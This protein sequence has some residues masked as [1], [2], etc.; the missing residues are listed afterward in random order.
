MELTYE[1]VNL[2]RMTFKNQFDDEPIEQIPDLDKE[3]YLFKDC[4]VVGFTYLFKL[5][6]LLDKHPELIYQLHTHMGDINNKINSVTPLH[7]IC[8]HSESD[9][10]PNIIQLLIDSG[11][12]INAKDKYNNTAFNNV[13]RNYNSDKLYEVLKLLIVNNAVVNTQNKD[14]MT[15]LH[16]ICRFNNS[17]RLPEIVQLL[18]DGGVDVN[19]KN[20]NNWT[21]LHHICG[22][23]ESDKLPEAIQLL[24]RAG[25]DVNT[26][27]TDES[28][29][30]QL[31]CL[32]QKSNKLVESIQLLINAGTNVNA[33]NIKG[34]NALKLLCL[35]SSSYK[36]PKLLELFELL[37]KAGSNIDVESVTKLKDCKIYDMIIQYRKHDFQQIKPFL[38]YFGEG[39]IK[40]LNY[41]E[42]FKKSVKSV[43]DLYNKIYYFPGN[44][45]AL[46][47]ESRFVSS[48]DTHHRQNKSHFLFN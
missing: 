42:L 8:W 29:A 20:I 35:R 22:N 24:I 23:C 31:I 37:I 3:Y 14:N 26:K 19:T 5:L 11:A 46:L 28:T 6:Y 41:F 27:N 21:A 38:G 12:D 7:F 48:F 33:I 1:E 2:Y 43:E 39:Q 32:H 4:K 36:L 34:S 18:I 45:G 47:C 17:D 16:H 30:L 13:C 25:V 10:L 40:L 44:I 9:E 15:P